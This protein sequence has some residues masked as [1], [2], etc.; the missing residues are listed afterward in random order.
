MKRFSWP[1]L[2]ALAAGCGDLLV[3]PAKAPARLAVSLSAEALGAVSVAGVRDAFDAA[4]S[5]RVVLLDG[6]TRTDPF[7]P[8]AGA[9]AD[10][11]LPFAPGDTVR[12]SLELPDSAVASEREVLMGVMLKG[13]GQ[14]L[15][16]FADSILLRP[17][18]T[19]RALVPVLLPVPASVVLRAER[20]TL[21]STTDSLLVQA[22]GLFATGDTIP[23][24]QFF[25]ELTSLDLDVVTVVDQG[26]RAVVR[27]VAP[28]AGR[29]MARASGVGADALD[30]V[31]VVVRP[32]PPAAAVF[33]S[34]VAGTDFACGLDA[35]GLLYCW[36]SNANGQF[37][38]GGTTSSPVPVPA[39][40]GLLFT[41]VSAGG[42][43]VCG[44]KAGGAMACW[45]S[46]SLGQL[47]IGSPTMGSA[48]LSPQAVP[49]VWREVSAGGEY[50]CAIDAEGFLQCWGCNCDG[51]LGIG[52]VGGSYPD[53][54]VVSRDPWSEVAA[55][56]Y[57]TCAVNVFGDARC[58]GYGAHGVL[59]NGADTTAAAP[60]PL[61]SGARWSE[62][63]VGLHH[64][65]AVNLDSREVFCWGFNGNGQLGLPGG[66]DGDTHAVPVLVRTGFT[67]SSL[68]TGAW[69]TCVLNEQAASYQCWG[70]D[71]D[72]QL[73]TVDGTGGAWI[74]VRAARGG[75][76]TCGRHLDGTTYCWGEGTAGQLGNGAGA[77]SPVPVAVAPPA[78]P[79]VTARMRSTGG[80]R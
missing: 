62:I 78:P 7:Q 43:H 11:V 41:T 4:D 70:S 53:P 77:S 58:W 38:N 73:G 1:A 60:V 31:V 8:Q 75:D 18:E 66:P 6:F 49:G 13:G 24:G 44:I 46:N 59:G 21:V 26:T 25:P 57:T 27:A 55:G 5:I 22:V 32:P 71:S 48:V 16:V 67:A 19:T 47:G 74:E 17:S 39:G 65:C 35:E 2:L 80:N 63:A 9:L 28:G 40:G 37:G 68:T 34:V 69:H 56:A 33:R 54:I 20:D 64:A 14:A 15:F 10:T 79:P 51:Q 45:G 3:T 42:A 36:G 76:F 61:Q 50:T 30:T 12:L 23:D 52:S 29:V 72:G